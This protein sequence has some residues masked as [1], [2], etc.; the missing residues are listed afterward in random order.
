MTVLEVA[1]LRHV[2]LLAPRLREPDRLEIWASGGN[3]PA[4]SLRKSLALSLFARTAFIDGEAAAMFGVRVVGD[5]AIPWLLTTDTVDRHPLEFYRAAKLIAA[6]LRAR[7][8]RMLQ[9]V[10]ARHPAALSFV[11]RLG[12]EVG[13]AEPFG[14]EQLPFHR[15]SIGGA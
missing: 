6:A 5:V 4:Q 14:L 15:V 7:F 13:A 10:D 9:M 1:T 12:F 3:R 2:H 11:E 8:P